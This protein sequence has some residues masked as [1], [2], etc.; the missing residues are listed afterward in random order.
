M[1]KLLLLSVV[2][3][4]LFSSCGVLLVGIKKKIFLIDAPKD[5]KVYQ[6]GKMLKIESLTFHVDEVGHTRTTYKYPGVRANIKKDRK[7]TIK[8]GEVSGE[9]EIQP[10]RQI[11]LLVIEGILTCGTFTIV[12]LL[13]GGDTKP[14][15]GYIDVPAVLNHE[16]FRTQKQLKKAGFKSFR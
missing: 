7:L 3:M 13:T 16:K 9:V 14:V 8:A 12:D 2:S 10:K 6:N 11:G 15:P 4:F 1:K 5:V